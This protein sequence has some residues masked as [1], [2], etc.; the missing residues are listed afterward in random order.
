M[1]LMRKPGR[2]YCSKEFAGRKL[3]GVPRNL[4]EVENELRFA[5][6]KHRFKL[7]EVNNSGLYHY[8]F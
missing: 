4:A 8:H 3:R 5:L 7:K 2:A 6:C 1:S